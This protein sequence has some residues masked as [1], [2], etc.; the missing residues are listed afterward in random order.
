[1]ERVPVATN[2][3]CDAVILC[4]SVILRFC[5]SVIVPVCVCLQMRDPRN[6]APKLR[7]AQLRTPPKTAS[8]D[9]PAAPS[10]VAAHSPQPGTTWAE[11][12]GRS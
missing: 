1:M 8:S 12:L 11:Q 5:D 4:D 7:R 2:R 3:M 10:P 6:L 9:S